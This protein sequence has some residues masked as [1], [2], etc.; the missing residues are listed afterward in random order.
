[1]GMRR[2]NGDAMGGKR[3]WIVERRGAVVLVI[4]QSLFGGENRG[5]ISC[6]FG[7]VIFFDQV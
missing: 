2:G 1:M 5:G 7:I 6:I 4:R 3:K